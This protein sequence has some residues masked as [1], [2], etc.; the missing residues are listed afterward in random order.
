MPNH[1]DPL[2]KIFLRKRWYR[3]AGNGS[4]RTTRHPAAV[5]IQSVEFKSV[6]LNLLLGEQPHEKYYDR[7]HDGNNLTEETD[8]TTLWPRIYGKAFV[9]NASTPILVRW[10]T[11]YSC[12]TTSISMLEWEHRYSSFH[13]SSKTNKNYRPLDSEPS[14]QQ[15][16]VV[17]PL[18][19]HSVQLTYRRQ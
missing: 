14:N 15:R 10:S 17:H 11:Y 9:R 5:R 16:F 4:F 8:A 13:L 3:R 2:E 6:L 19:L 1:L 18:M 12:D 7:C